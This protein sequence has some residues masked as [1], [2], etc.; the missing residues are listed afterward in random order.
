M[1]AR[2]PG[3][4]STGS[5]NPRSVRRGS[6]FDTTAFA[7]ELLAGCQRDAC[8]A[9][10]LHV[11]APHFGVRAD[12]GAGRAGRRGERRRQ[13]SEAASHEPLAA[14]ARAHPHQQHRRA[15]GRSRPERGAENTSGR[16]GSAQRL[17]LEPLRHEIGGGHR[18]PSQQAIRVFLS[19]AP[20]SAPHH[21]HRPH[22]GIRGLLD[23]GRR[24][25]HHIAGERANSTRELR[26]TPG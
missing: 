7:C 5:I 8:R 22:I 24:V 23:V 18:R 13:R 10:V 26:R 9:A 19:K 12:L 11:D 25:C 6:A 16:D 17:R 20:E 1:R 3:S 14:V 21:Q 15:A 4:S 2:N